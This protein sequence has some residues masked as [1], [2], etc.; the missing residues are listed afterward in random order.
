MATILNEMFDNGL[1][2]APRTVSV[3]LAESPDALRTITGNKSV[4][5]FTVRMS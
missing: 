1:L 5:R 3:P 4:G 2:A